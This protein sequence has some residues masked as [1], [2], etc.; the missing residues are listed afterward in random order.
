MNGSASAGPVIRASGWLLRAA[1]RGDRAAQHE[2]LTRYEP[3]VRSVVR[4]LRLPAG[5]EREDLAQEARI[6]LWAAIRAW[7]PDRGSFPPFASRCVHNQA[8]MALEAACA[9]KHRVLTYAISL[10]SEHGGDPMAGDER[11]PSRIHRFHHPSDGRTDP[12]ACL[13]VHEQLTCLRRALP[14][15]SPRQRLALA[16][17]LNGLTH[18]QLAPVLGGTRKAASHVVLRTRRRLEAALPRAA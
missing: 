18:E 8:L 10:D 15:L 1:Q 17:A 14:T 6:G 12:E 4:R 2:L 5:C 13:L 9:N 16:G 3:L 7:R 11:A